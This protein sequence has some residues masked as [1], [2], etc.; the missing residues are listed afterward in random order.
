MTLHWYQIDTTLWK[1]GSNVTNEQEV[2]G[3]LPR[4]VTGQLS[5]YLSFQILDKIQI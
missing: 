3:F 1:E 4:K 5:Q 2:W